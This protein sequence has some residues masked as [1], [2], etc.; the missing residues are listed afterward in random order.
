MQRHGGQKIRSVF[1]DL[2]AQMEQH[3]KGGNHI[4]L[5][6]QAGNSGHSGLPIAKAQGLEDEGHAAANGGQQRGIVVFH[7]AESAVCKAEALEEPE[8]DGGGQNHSASPLDKAPA[9]LP[10]G[11]QYVVGRRHMILGQLHDEGRRIAG[12]G[13]GLFEH[14]AGEHNRGHAHKIGGYRHQAAAAE[15]SAGKQADNGQLRAAGHKAGGHNGHA[16]IS[17]VF[18]GAAGHDAGHAAAR[19]DQ[20]GNKALAGKAE[21][22]EDTVHDECDASHIANI[23]QYGQ[24][25]EQHQH[26]GN[27]AQ[28]GADAADNAV[29]H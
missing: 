10:G 21:F 16:A 15:Q 6:N 5:G 1:G 17:F 12:K 18:N 29:Y 19:A 9:P 28:H 4:F 2:F 20:H 23:F 13:F 3:A 14:D 24:H 8:N 7:H 25:Q 26:L 11:P 27:K 22:A